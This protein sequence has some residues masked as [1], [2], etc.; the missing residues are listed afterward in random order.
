VA[1]AAAC[2]IAFSA[3]SLA[4]ET[5]S[6][7]D[8]SFDELPEI[9][10]TANR[11]PTPRS[12]TVGVVEVVR[13]DDVPGPTGGVADLISTVPGVDA[14]GTFP[15]EK[16]T[17]NLRGL[18]GSYGTQRT[19]VMADGVPL[20]DGYL[21][22]ADLRLLGTGLFE[23]IEVL[24]GPGSALYG[25]SALG[26][27]VNLI[28][29]RAGDRPEGEVSVFGGDFGTFGAS[30]RGGARAGAFDWYVSA[31]A[32]RTDG[33]IDNIDGTDRDWESA[34]YGA[35]L[36]YD[37]G[38]GHELGFMTQHT[39][40]E[41]QR[42]AYDEEI[43]QGTY[44]LSYRFASP[45]TE[46]TAFDARLS[47]TAGDQQFTWK[48]GPP[49]TSDRDMVTDGIQVQQTL[50]VADRHRL[51]FGGEVLAEDVDVTEPAGP[52]EME[53]T[54]NAAFIQDEIDL[55]EWRLTLGARLDHEDIFGTEVSP[56]VG[57]V[58]KLGERDRLYAS[59]GKAYRAPAA[60]DL[61]LPPTFVGP[62]TA[63]AG[64]P[65]LDPEEHWAFELGG[66]HGLGERGRLEWSAFYDLGSDVWDYMLEVP[67]PPFEIHIPQNVGE[68]TTAGAELKGTVDLG[69]GLS[70]GAAYTF[71]HAEYVEFESDPT[72][73]GNEV[74]DIPAH[75]GS[76]S[77]AKEW[78]EGGK[79]ELALR[80][81]G[82]RYTDPDNTAAGE[83]DGY[84]V[85]DARCA[86]PVA[87]G[88]AVTLA[89]RNI[90]DVN[91]EVNTT[92]VGTVLRQPGRSVFA[93]VRA[94]F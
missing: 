24:R 82:S 38:G 71:V 64:N 29:R 84:S 80:F 86:V 90:F 87:K 14:Q 85:L 22:D 77:L 26:G 63:Y 39:T 6:G 51:V 15:G 62:T 35:R 81:A 53:S 94:R 21:G 50:V 13:P 40:G 72:I 54:T 11:V 44:Q 30:A 23:R 61:Y 46:G 41:G 16:T 10:V 2:C 75:S 88:L 55:G 65:D 73:E 34:S 68:L 36:G 49:G 5:G 8:T 12:E 9:V 33:Y 27:V 69:A 66:D 57:L 59:V 47:R 28:P 52:V 58:R 32:L 89:V 18:Q 76:V 78:G 25:G 3:E 93:G 31:E 45:M 4:Q 67:A 48:L 1:A 20:N 42:D 79:A 74:E 60:S 19:L 92:M 17:L 7:F 70:F 37:L 91:Y 83:L 56:R 43:A